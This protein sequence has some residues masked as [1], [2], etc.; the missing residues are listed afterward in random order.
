[1][2]ALYHLGIIEGYLHSKGED[3]HPVRVWS[4]LKALKEHLQAPDPTTHIEIRTEPL[5]PKQTAKLAQSIVKASQAEVR[6]EG[7]SQEILT[8][9]DHQHVEPTREVP[10][11]RGEWAQWQLDLLHEMKARKEPVHAISK[12]T[13]KTTPQVNNMWYKLQKEAGKQEHE[14]QLD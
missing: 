4:S 3:A 2:S 11:K 13:E 14:I 8:D 6:C 9:M 10:T 5:N 12:A 1:M 7:G